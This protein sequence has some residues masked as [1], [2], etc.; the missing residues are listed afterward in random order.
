VSCRHMTAL[1]ERRDEA[2]KRYGVDVEDTAF[3]I[4]ELAGGVLAQISSS[5]ASRVK[6]D[7]LLQIK[8]DGTLG[9]AVCGLHRCFVQPLVATPKPFFDPE[10]PPGMVFDDQWQEMPDVEPARG[11]YRA[12]WE[13]FLRHVAEDAPFPSPLIEGA[14]GVQLAEACYKSN[15]ERRWIDLPPLKV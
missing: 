10:R 8:V 13:L 11:S 1:P 9:S 7:D 5:W 4:F 14:K 15:R 3:A 6:R 2:G 12:G